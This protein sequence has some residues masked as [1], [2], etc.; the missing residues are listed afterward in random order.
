MNATHTRH[1]LCLPQ[2]SCWGVGQK[3]SVGWCLYFDVKQN[4]WTNGSGDGELSSDLRP[5]LIQ[6]LSRSKTMREAFFQ[7]EEWTMSA[8][9]ML[10]IWSMFAFHALFISND[11]VDGA[12]LGFTIGIIG[13]FLLGPLC[14]LVSRYQNSVAFWIFMIL[15]APLLAAV[16]IVTLWQVF[17]PIFTF[18]F[19]IIAAAYIRGILFIVLDENTRGLFPFPEMR[20]S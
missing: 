20:R 7:F 12:R 6:N 3:D 11:S 8:L 13:V 14:I 15:S 19:I 16:P 2:L 17:H 4:V 5:K 18:L 1:L 10:S 9:I